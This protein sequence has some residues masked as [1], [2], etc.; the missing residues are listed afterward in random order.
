M[1]VT[2]E[3]NEIKV[4]KDIM[5]PSG[6][7]AESTEGGESDDSDENA[8]G[9]A[10]RR[11]EDPERSPGSLYLQRKLHSSK[12]TADD[13]TYRLRSRLVSRSE[14]E[15][16]R[17]KEQIVLVGS[18]ESEHATTSGRENTSPGK[19]EPTVGHS[20]NL[21]SRIES[22]SKEVRDNN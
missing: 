1:V 19:A 11:V 20:Y 21:R 3:N 4:E 7:L 22:T 14:R 2:E 6:L 17:A 15:V 10:H 8:I 12:N 18:P 9:S 16:G 13:I 5:I